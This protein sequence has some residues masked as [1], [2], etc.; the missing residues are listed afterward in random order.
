MLLFLCNMSK[1]QQIFFDFDGTICDSYPGKK[2]AFLK[3]IN[4]YKANPIELR[5]RYLSQ[6]TSIKKA[7]KKQL[8]ISDK[9][10]L[11][12]LKNQFEK[13]YEQDFYL[14]A[15]LYPGIIELLTKLNKSSALYIVSAKPEKLVLALLQHFKIKHFFEAI[16]CVANTNGYRNK[17]ELL[18]NLKKHKKSVMIGDQAMDVF[19]AKKNHMASISVTYGYGRKSE[20]LN[21]NPD[22]IVASPMDLNSFL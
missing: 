10:R 7:F 3:T 11:N 20:L 2:L 8:S 4:N 14:N 16:H 22:F 1:Y 15:E 13:H 12:E 19:A 17:S 18:A 5:T 6:N 21:S 9:G